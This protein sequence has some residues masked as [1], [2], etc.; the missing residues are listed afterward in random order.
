[1][2]SPK[3]KLEPDTTWQ[4]FRNEVN[5]P[6]VSGMGPAVLSGEAFSTQMKEF[7]TDQ[8]YPENLGAWDDAQKLVLEAL[9]PTCG[10]FHMWTEQEAW[11]GDQFTQPI[12]LATSSGFGISHFGNGDKLSALLDEIGG[13]LI[14]A[15]IAKD[16]EALRGKEPLIAFIMKYSLK[17]EKRKWQKLL[18]KLTRVFAANNLIMTFNGRR[19]LGD[20]CGKFM[21]AAANGF[22]EAACGRPMDR[23]GW[24]TLISRMFWEFSVKMGFDKDVK[25]WDKMYPIFMHLAVN[26]VIAHLA[27]NYELAEMVLRVG[28]RL[29]CCPGVCHIF[30]TLFVRPKDMPSG[31]MA[32][33]IRNCIAM[34]LVYAYMFCKHVP[35]EMRNAQDFRRNLRCCFLGD[36]N[37]L[38]PRTEFYYFGRTPQEIEETMKQTFLELGPWELTSPRDD[39]SP[40]NPLTLEFAGYVSVY[41][42]EAQMFIPR[43]SYEKILA[44][45]E[46]YTKIPRSE[47]PRVV[48]L[49]RYTAAF[50][51]CFPLMWSEDEKERK[52][53]TMIF[54]KRRALIKLMMLSPIIEERAAALGAP[55]L[56]ATAE[57][58]FGKYVEVQKR[59][60]GTEWYLDMER[61][62]ALAGP[63]PDPGIMK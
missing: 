2:G 28:W 34:F 21:N 36:D 44:I 4:H 31:D 60:S 55:T 10:G 33:I 41:V 46:W 39:G 26:L 59:F 23:G 62:V 32:T 52:L 58:Y 38:V 40:A 57:L 1:M 19:V 51:K 7:T 12:D 27:G 20:F 37:C 42:P 54:F 61:T 53:V 17:D 49:S 50:Q 11:D 13:P 6:Y 63:E 16:W 25:M 48:H 30:G 29:I 24:H 15:W 5:Y 47:P 14:R 8:G 35:K 56:S 3:T 43:L 45:M 18:D 22:I 9:E